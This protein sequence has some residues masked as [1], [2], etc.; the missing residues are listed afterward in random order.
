MRVTTDFERFRN[1]FREKE[2]KSRL[3]PL[4]CKNLA[5]LLEHGVAFPGELV[6]VRL[7]TI[8]HAA[9][10]ILDALAQTS[11]IGSAGGLFLRRSPV[12]LSRRHRDGP[13]N[14]GNDE[15][16]FAPHG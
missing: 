11:D 10:F 7:Q 8:E 2:S 16:R 15:D 12:A 13:E 5:M 3:A 1:G 14:E 9:L 6:L 4:A